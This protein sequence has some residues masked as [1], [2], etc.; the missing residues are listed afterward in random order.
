QLE[1]QITIAE[2]DTLLARVTLIKQYF[3]APETPV[4]SQ[5]VALWEQST[6]VT[7]STVN[8]IPYVKNFQGHTCKYI[9]PKDGEYGALR[10]DGT[11][12]GAV[13][14]L[15][16]GRGDLIISSLDNTIA[17]SRAIHFLVAN[18][19]SGAVMVMKRTTSVDST[20]SRYVEEFSG[21]VWLSCAALTGFLTLFLYGI[22]KKSPFE[23][24]KIPLQDTWLLVIGA[25][26]AQGSE[27]VYAGFSS[28]IAVIVTYT[29]TFL[30]ATYYTS[31]L[32]AMLTVQLP[33]Y[34]FN[35]FQS[36][37]N[38]RSY[39]I[40][41]VDGWSTKTEIQYSDNPL[42]Q[43]VWVELISAKGGVVHSMD[44]GLQ[45]ALDERLIMLINQQSYMLDK[46]FNKNLFSVMPGILFKF[47][48]GYSVAKGSP[49]I[50]LLNKG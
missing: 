40:G 28:R 29:S 35:G 43:R 24:S 3:V 17:R 10:S 26:A 20:W 42:L 41:V 13:G 23:P 48:S 12:S 9:T 37:L 49:Y 31:W 7:S 6:G 39:A 8:G 50:E 36:V 30:I 19:L 25:F 22:I 18:E 21:G 11:W 46:N 33:A 45:R 38:D 4:M 47:P 32:Y 34:P 15:V 14:E 2:V 5:Q 27:R 44:E 16:A 1:F